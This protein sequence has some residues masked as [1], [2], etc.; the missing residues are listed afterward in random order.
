MQP[1]SQTV[2][3]GERAR[4]VG[5]MLIAAYPGFILQ[6]QLSSSAMEPASHLKS[7]FNTADAVQTCV[8]Q[9]T[10]RFESLKVY[11]TFSLSKVYSCGIWHSCPLDK[12]SVAGVLENRF[13]PAGTHKLR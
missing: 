13:Q 8:S 4:A 9:T 11:A 5:R 3:E 10:T 7:N 2:K 1:F 12:T 6:Y